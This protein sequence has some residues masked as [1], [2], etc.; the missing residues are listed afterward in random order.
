VGSFGRILLLVVALAFLAAPAAQ[1]ACDPA[2]VPGGNSQID[3]YTETVPGACGDHQ[4][5]TGGAGGAG[6]HSGNGPAAPAATVEELQSA[7]PDGAATA[8]LV[9]DVAPGPDT[10]SGDPA[11]GGSDQAGGSKPSGSTNA[12]E[13]GA[14]DGDG[15]VLSGVAR[16]L[17]GADDSAGLGIVLPL[18]LA[19]S[20]IGALAYLL[21]RR[22][23][24][25]Q[26]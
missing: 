10:G 19:A 4:S 22:D 20:L 23:R 1:A 25:P 8:G 3:E 14:A 9:D 15:S 17:G 13:G 26:T 12:Q 11:T 24:T 16:S 21:R 6:G 7:G 18:V 2:T 5:Q